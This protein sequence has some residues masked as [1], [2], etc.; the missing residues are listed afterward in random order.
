MFLWVRYFLH[1]H[2][3]HLFPLCGLLQGGHVL[4]DLLL[5]VRS[6]KPL[7]G[8]GGRRVC[9]SGGGG[10]GGAVSGGG[11]VRGVGTS[12]DVI[13]GDILLLGCFSFLHFD[14]LLDI[15][16]WFDRLILILLDLRLLRWLL[17][18]LFPYKVIRPT[19]RTVVIIV[20]IGRVRPGCDLQLLLPG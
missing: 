3:A 7:P 6:L 10:G 2:L 18:T 20:L 17:I 1:L 19:F 13:L 4:T 9:C 11:G 8:D 5:L 12:G 16:R 14:L 15:L